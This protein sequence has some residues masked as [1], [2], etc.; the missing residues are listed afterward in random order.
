[1][2]GK[3]IFLVFFSLSLIF[4]GIASAGQWA[5]IY[6]N[7][8]LGSFFANSIQQTSDGGYIVA[9]YNKLPDRP[10]SQGWVL[11][12]DKDG[13]IQWQK[14]YGYSQRDNVA[15][16]I[17]QTSDGGYIVAGWTGDLKYFNVWV[18]KLDKDG[19]IQ[20]QKIYSN[21]KDLAPRYSAA[22]S[23]QQTSDGG[24]IV[25]G[26]TLGIYDDVWVLK[27]DKDGNI[28]WQ[29][30]YGYHDRD[31]ANSIQQT[32]D[33]G[34]IVAGWTESFGQGKRD[35]WVLKLDKDGNIQW[36]K[37]YGGAEEDVANSIQQTSDGGY[38]VAGWTESFG[39]GKKDVWV[40]KLDANGNVQWQKTYGGAGEDVANSIQQTSDGGYIVVGWTDSFGQGKKDV[41][42]LKLD[43]NGNVQWQKTY[44]G[45]EEDF[46]AN[47]I[48]Q[49]SDGGYI[50]AGWTN[51]SAYYGRYKYNR[52]L[53]LKLDRNGN[54]QGCS[55]V[56]SSNATVQMT[57]ASGIDSLAV[58]SNA[59]VTFGINIYEIRDTSVSPMQICYYE[60]PPSPFTDVPPDYW[61]FNYI[62]AIWDAGITKGCNPPQNDKFCPEDVVTRA[63][64]AAFIIRA[65]E[66]EPTSYNANPY[67]AD[68]PPTHWAFKYV[69]R[70]KER[71]IAQ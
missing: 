21:L 56:G 4:A 11:K 58:I 66:G 57:N 31:A 42:V 64:M 28:Q 47:S 41:W 18:L 62:K 65:I 33:G 25:A 43:A 69:Q 61:A 55:I 68:V 20:W 51:S 14:A 59:F 1:M 23:I 19:N 9:G 22:N 7:F 70:V 54:I 8:T 24:Y 71:G 10:Y 60:S 6:G 2:R 37:T 12:L 52:V 34:Y 45:A 5:K 26:Y 63:Q 40:L 16:S 50:V 17:Q 32:S 38:I 35:V 27:L 3:W 49:T 15:N 67:F 44:G 53:V 30:T 29:K 36:Q 46:F 48:Q 39:Q 13:N